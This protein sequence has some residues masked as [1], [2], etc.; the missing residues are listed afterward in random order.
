[1]SCL[2]YR[3][4]MGSK[5]ALHLVVN[6]TISPSAAVF[7]KALLNGFLIDKRFFPTATFAIIRQDLVGMMTQFFQ[8][9]D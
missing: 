6:M 7:L 2:G 3:Q 1:M 5:P 4:C 8:W 9:A